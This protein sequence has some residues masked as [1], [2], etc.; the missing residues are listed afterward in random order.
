MGGARKE[1]KRSREGGTYLT[2]VYK[3]D[4]NFE[5]THVQQVIY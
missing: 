4:T 3:T 5:Q 1:M 2:K